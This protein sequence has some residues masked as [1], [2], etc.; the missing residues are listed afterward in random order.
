MT[1]STAAPNVQY[2]IGVFIKFL[3][4]EEIVRLVNRGFSVKYYT[5]AVFSN[6][7]DTK[8]NIGKSVAQT[9]VPVTYTKI[10]NCTLDNFVQFCVDYC[11]RYHIASDDEFNFEDGVEID[12]S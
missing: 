5:N 8:D 2:P 7:A 12:L 11:G 3:Y 4:R 1:T 10:K 6:N 9:D